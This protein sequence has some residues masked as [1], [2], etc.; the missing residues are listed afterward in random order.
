MYG[1]VIVSR[2]SS[3]TEFHKPSVSEMK[4]YTGRLREFFDDDEFKYNTRKE[5]IRSKTNSKHIENH[6]K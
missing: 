5:R 6:K 4:K 1:A 2:R 3:M